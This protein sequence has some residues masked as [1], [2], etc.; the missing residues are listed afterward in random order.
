[1]LIQPYNSDWIIQFEAIAN[2]LKA[3]LQGCEFTIQHIGSTAIPDLDAKPIIDIDIIF[4]NK[5]EFETIKAGLLSIGYYHNGNQGIEDREVFKRVGNSSNRVLDT[6]PH[7]LYVCPHTS[8]ALERHILMRNYLR[9]H[10]WARDKY[11]RMKY[12]LAEQ[13]QQD[14]KVYAILKEQHVNGFIDE[15]VKE[16]RATS[17]TQ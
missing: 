4:Y 15:V 12:E 3:C 16:E 9:K 13:A 1:M 11:Q 17:Q 8:L 5:S 2:D 10:N 6:I 7:H 14:R